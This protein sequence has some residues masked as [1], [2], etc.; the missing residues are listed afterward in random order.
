MSHKANRK[1]IGRYVGNGRDVSKEERVLEF[2]SRKIGSENLCELRQD[3]TEISSFFKDRGLA[4]SQIEYDKI[5]NCMDRLKGNSG[6]IL[7][8]LRIVASKKTVSDAAEGADC[9]ASDKV[10]ECIS[11]HSKNPEALLEI[12]HALVSIACCTKNQYLVER[13][14]EYMG[15]FFENPEKAIELSKFLTKNAVLV[16]D[17]GEPTSGDEHAIARMRRSFN[18]I[19]LLNMITMITKMKP[20]KPLVQTD[21]VEIANEK[22]ENLN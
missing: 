2:S 19:Q 9:L 6:S 14:A 22:K 21:F 10:A 15:T 8:E 18:I 11:K 7:Y 16:T 12:E 5:K 4:L 17:C 1:D 20:G 3:S 13:M